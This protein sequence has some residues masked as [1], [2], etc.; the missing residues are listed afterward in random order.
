MN[1]W[2]NNTPSAMRHHHYG[3]VQSPD[4]DYRAYRDARKFIVEADAE[5]EREPDPPYLV[6]VALAFCA[7]I[8][9]AL[10]LATLDPAASQRTPAADAQPPAT[11]EARGGEGMGVSNKT[12]GDF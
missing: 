9:L 10:L 3:P 1:H 11:F 4:F 12:P 2:T 7:L 8:S 6:C 5:D